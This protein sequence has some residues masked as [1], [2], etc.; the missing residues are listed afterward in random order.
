MGGNSTRAERGRVITLPFQGVKLLRDHLPSPLGW[1]K[2]FL[3]FRQLWFDFPTG[4]N[5]LKQGLKAIVEIVTDKIGQNN[6]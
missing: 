2:V 6:A 4:E 3:P 1:A 5:F